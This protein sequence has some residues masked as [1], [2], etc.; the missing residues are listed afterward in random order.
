MESTKARKAVF[1]GSWYPSS[2]SDCEREIEVFLTE[3]K[4]FKQGIENNWNAEQWEPKHSLVVWTR[5]TAT[6]TINFTIEQIK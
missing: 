6:D 3:G 4:N 5:V 2:A 1:A